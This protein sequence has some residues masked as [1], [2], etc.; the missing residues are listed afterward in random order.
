TKQVGVGGILQE[1]ALSNLQV[2]ACGS[3]MLEPAGFSGSP[4]LTPA[5]LSERLRHGSELLGSVQ[6]RALLSELKEQYDII[7]LDT[8]A[9]STVTDAAVLVPIVDHVLLVVAQAQADRDAVR[10]VRDQLGVMNVKSMGV[11]VNRTEA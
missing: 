9:L 1:T 11:V 4:Q 5:G 7:L 10:Q 6:M 8:P 3:T 2:I